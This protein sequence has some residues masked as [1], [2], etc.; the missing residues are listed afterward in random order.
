MRQSLLIA[1]LLLCAPSMAQAQ[2]KE[3]LSTPTES[4]GLVTVEERGDAAQIVNDVNSAPN[5]GYVKGYRV[6]IFFDNGQN[7]R[8]LAVEARDKFVEIYPEIKVYMS[9]ENPY[10][11]VAAGDCIMQEEA[12]ILLEKIRSNFP[13]AFIQRDNIAIEDL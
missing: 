4:G 12:V 6:G 10:F 5:E 7:A 1:M 8:Y 3:R 2:I 9:Y 13:K 11:K